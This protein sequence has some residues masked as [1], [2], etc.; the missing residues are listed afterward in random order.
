MFHSSAV[1][2]W[3]Y[4]YFCC[5]ICVVCF[6]ITWA[7]K[8]T[9]EQGNTSISI[10]FSDKPR[11]SELIFS[12]TRPRDCSEVLKH[13]NKLS[14]VYTIWP[15][16]NITQNK[17]L[18]VYCDMNVAGEGW[19]VIQRRGD[20]PQP[21]RFDIQWDKYKTGFGDIT[22]DF[23]LGNDNIYALSNQGPCEIRFDLEDT[24]GNRRFA[25]YKK[26]WIDDEASF[27]TLH[28]G[29]YSGNAG[30]GMR[31]YNGR[32]FVTEDQDHHQMAQILNG[33]WWM[34][35]WPFC[36]LNGIYIPGVHDHRS[37]HWY[38]WHKNKG[39][40]TTEIKIKLK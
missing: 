9:S 16:S 6:L 14:G 26:F 23:W 7:W 17:P 1:S 19:T 5:A 18:Q 3:R 15:R 12:Q 28:I 20:Y 34:F 13:G 8:L 10:V 33:A 29:D 36:H 37:M 11:V 25:I 38:E 21:Q 30:N 31:F 2:H 24:K 39:L 35:E 4:L 27:Y 40:A 32:P 22:K